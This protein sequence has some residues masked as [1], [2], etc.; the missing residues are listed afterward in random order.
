MFIGRE[1]ELEFFEDRYSAPGAQLIVIVALSEK[2][3]R[4]GPCV[5]G[6]RE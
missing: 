6:R 5:S 2:G 1:Q 4:N 3:I